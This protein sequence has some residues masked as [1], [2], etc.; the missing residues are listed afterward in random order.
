M[1]FLSVSI[2][3]LSATPIESPPIVILGPAARYNISMGEP[4]VVP[5]IR[6]DL[7]LPTIIPG[8]VLVFIWGVNHRPGQEFYVCEGTIVVVVFMGECIER[9][10]G[11]I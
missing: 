2:F 5:C 7:S 9:G 10:R 4:L 3:L 8:D 6:S 11:R 1:I